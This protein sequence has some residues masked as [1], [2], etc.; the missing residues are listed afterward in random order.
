[1]AKVLVVG[2]AVTKEAELQVYET[3]IFLPLFLFLISLVVLFMM[4]VVVAVT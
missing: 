4:M 1:M 3:S 2:T